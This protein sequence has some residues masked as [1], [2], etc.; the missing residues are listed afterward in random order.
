[1][2]RAPSVPLYFFAFLSFPH[3]P[4]HNRLSETVV[5]DYLK[6]DLVHTPILIAYGRYLE[7]TE[8]EI[9]PLRSL[10]LCFLQNRSNYKTVLYLREKALATHSI[11]LPGKFHGWRSLVGCSAWGRKES[12]TTEQLH[13]HFHTLEKEMATHSSTLTWEISWMEEPGRLQ[14]M[15]S[16]RVRHDWATSFPQWLSSKE[17]ACKAGHTIGSLGWRE[18]LEEGMVTHSNILA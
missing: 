14:S 15:G 6:T 12:D 16:Q 7:L 9:Y 4:Y 8:W 5:T 10:F 18:P 3:I 1:M 13:F 17:C 2:R 11:L